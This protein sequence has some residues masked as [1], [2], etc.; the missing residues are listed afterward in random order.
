[1]RRPQNLEKNLTLVLTKQLFLLSTVKAS[2]R[3]FQFFVP[4]SVKLN[5]NC[6][7]ILF[8]VPENTGL[9][10]ICAFPSLGGH[11]EILKSETKVLG[12]QYKPVFCAVE[13]FAVHLHFARI[14]NVYWA[15]TPDNLR[16]KLILALLFSP[17]RKIRNQS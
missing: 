13:I 5:F 3:F 1:M 17:K 15:R 7:V 10:V 2:G 6:N 8:L 11:D 9:T 4:F 14:A 12:T 16:M